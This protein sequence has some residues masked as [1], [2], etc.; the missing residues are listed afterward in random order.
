[1]SS[2]SDTKTAENY[3]GKT[4][5]GRCKWFNSKNGYGFITITYD[6]GSI[7]DDIFVHHNSIKVSNEQ[8]KYLVLGEYVQFKIL[9]NESGKHKYYAD[10]VCGIR[11]GKLMCE[12]RRENKNLRNNYKKTTYEEDDFNDDKINYNK[13]NESSWSYVVKGKSEKG[14]SYPPK[15]SRENERS[16]G[17]KSFKSRERKTSSVRV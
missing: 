10:E 13:E 7:G 3:A 2:N 6:D 17:E 8:Y 9:E 15:T 1:M 14:K 5:I 12:T 16:R 11:G 4:F